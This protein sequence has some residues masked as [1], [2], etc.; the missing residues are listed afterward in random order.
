MSAPYSDRQN[1]RH[2]AEQPPIALTRAAH[3]K[4]DRHRRRKAG[5][6]YRIRA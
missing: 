1:E 3:V 4:L 6:R 2:S 5:I